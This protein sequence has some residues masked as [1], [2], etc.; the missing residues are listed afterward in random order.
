MSEHVF[1]C[2]NNGREPYLILSEGACDY[3]LGY[4][5]AIEW[6]GNLHDSV[7]TGCDCAPDGAG[8]MGAV[9]AYRD[10][11]RT[12]RCSV[13]GR[14]TG[15]CCTVPKPPMWRVVCGDGEARDHAEHGGPVF[16]IESNADYVATYLD[17]PDECADCGPHQV[18]RE[19]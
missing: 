1:S 11:I 6:A 9:I 2:P 14:A 19:L 8:A 13:C 12:E 15:G 5:A 3:C 17:H 7:A 16:D 18:E 4:R 10:L